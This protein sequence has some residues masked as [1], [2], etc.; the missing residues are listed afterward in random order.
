[1][2]ILLA[3]LAE[4]LFLLL[5]LAPPPRPVLALAHHLDLVGNSF[6]EFSP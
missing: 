5:V 3:L 6:K 4:L 2:I 1:M